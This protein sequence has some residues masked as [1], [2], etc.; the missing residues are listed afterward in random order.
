[1]ITKHYIDNK[2]IVSI[3]RT[4]RIIILMENVVLKQSSLLNYRDAFFFIGLF[5]VVPLPLLLFVMNKSK[6]PKTNMIISDH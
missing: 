2:L 5:F 6:K 4:S 3:G 1:M